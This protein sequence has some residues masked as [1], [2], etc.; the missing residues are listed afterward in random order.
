MWKNVQDTLNVE[1]TEVD[2]TLLDLLKKNMGVNDIERKE[3]DVSATMSFRSSGLG[4][5]CKRKHLLASLFGEPLDAKGIDAKASWIFGIGT[6]YHY[7]FQN[8]YLRSLGNVLK[9]HWKCKKCGNIH[10]GGLGDEIG[11]LGGH[12][13][14][15]IAYNGK[16]I[17]H[18]EKCSNCGREEQMEYIEL[19]FRDHANNVTGHCD[20]IL[21]FG[22]DSEN[23]V[24]ELKTINNLSY[25]DPSM[26]AKP[27][28]EHVEQV[29][30]YM[31][32]SGLKKARIVYILKG[33]NDFRKAI[34]E[35]VV[36]YDK[37]MMS[38]IFIMLRETRDLLAKLYHHEDFFDQPVNTKN[39]KGFRA[40]PDS[41]KELLPGR[42]I[43]C[44]TKTS[45]KAKYCSRKKECFAL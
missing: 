29:N 26:G 35:H 4:I 14:M 16:W 17:D 45:F 39:A 33:E 21:D 24:L 9:G 3:T 31:H 11:Y 36:Y 43:E 6:A 22:D 20:G 13:N 18:P 41:L 19:E 15:N 7:Q 32:Y 10:M 28:K 2:T 23:E 27:K 42:C 8:G 44:Q 38:K 12:S 25:V 1:K 40:I 5:F 37:E 34:V 30:A